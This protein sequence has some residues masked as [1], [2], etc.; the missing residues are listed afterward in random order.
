MKKY[1]SFNPG[2]VWLDSEGKRIQAHGGSILYVDG[3]YYWYGENKE[4][5]L[6]GSEVWHWGVKLYSSTDLYNWD[7]RGIICPPVTDDYDN[8]L[9]FTQYMDRPHIVYNKGTKK[10]VMWLKIMHR[11]KME[12]QHMVIA[13]ADKITDTFKV[14]ANRNILNMS[15]GDFDI[16]CDDKTQKAYIYFDKVHD[17][18]D[19]ENQHTSIVCAELTDDYTDVNGT[20]REILARGKTEL[21]FEAPAFMQRNGIDYLFVSRT[22]GYIPNPTEYATAKDYFGPW[23][24]IGTVHENDTEH[25]SF[26]SQICSVFKHPHKKD[27][28]IALADRWLTNLPEKIEGNY[29]RE[30]LRDAYGVGEQAMS[31]EEYQKI[32]ALNT[33]AVRTMALADYVWLPIEFNG[34]K[35]TIR[36]YDSWKTEDFE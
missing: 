23:E 31:T 19:Y 6:A 21:G 29:Y 35:P 15:S 26:R 4:K 2:K 25:M 10:F 5:T 17:Y 7:D 27:L 3:V 18:K 11:G 30:C 28:Y 24:L 33:P 22:T 36:W 1:D 14:I 13:V 8:W 34:D 20:Y 32:R 16:F 12:D 9:H